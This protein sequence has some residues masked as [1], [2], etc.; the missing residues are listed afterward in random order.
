M[1]KKRKEKKSSINV[2][3]YLLMQ[4]C[5]NAFLAFST[6]GIVDWQDL[7]RVGIRLTYGYVGCII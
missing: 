7:G 6:D 2:F 1:I 5:N 3:I 4:L